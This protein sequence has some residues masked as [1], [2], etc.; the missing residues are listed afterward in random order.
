LSDTAH[1]T[2]F[3]D[4]L[5]FPSRTLTMTSL[6]HITFSL[7]FPPRAPLRF[8]QLACLLA[9]TS[10]SAQAGA[11]GETGIDSSGNYRQEVAWCRAN[12]TSVAL[13]DCLKG[14]GAAQVEKRR[15]T[16]GNNGANYGS[17]ALLRC[18]PFQGE[19]RAACM[20]RVAGV[21]GSSGSV[22]GGGRLTWAETAVVPSNV[23]TVIVLE[24]PPAGIVVVPPTQK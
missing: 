22:Q 19:D 12:T 3:L 17:N 14:S 2:L 1:G 11:T 13:T 18:E 20:A 10:A 21:G 4:W 16:L 23:T 6:H 24:K 7:P 15:G 8:W 9:V 5:I